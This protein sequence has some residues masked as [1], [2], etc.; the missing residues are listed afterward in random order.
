M[1]MRRT[2]PLLCLLLVCDV[3][4]AET[5]KLKSGRII[6][7]K[8]VEHTADA[9]KV[10][11]GIGVVTTYYLDEIESIDGESNADRTDLGKAT[12]SSSILGAGKELHLR[13]VPTKEGPEEQVEFH[14]DG[15][16]SMPVGKKPFLVLNRT[17]FSKIELKENLWGTVLLVISLKDESKE[18]MLRI[19]NENIGR[20]FVITD[21]DDQAYYNVSIA[22]TID[23]RTSGGS[24]FK[25]KEEIKDGFLV[26]SHF[27][28]AASQAQAKFLIDELMPEGV[29]RRMKAV[30]KYDLSS[31]K[32][33]TIYKIH[34][35][36]GGSAEGVIVDKTD[37]YFILK[38][39]GDMLI[40]FPLEDI[41]TQEA[42]DSGIKQVSGQMRMEKKPRL[43]GAPPF[44]PTNLY[45]KAVKELD[46]HNTPGIGFVSQYSKGEKQ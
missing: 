22:Q 36:G 31:L 46:Y 4:F 35:G 25:I 30:D 15:H 1:G 38:T 37:E 13:W 45:A 20:S 23:H 10:D 16:I 2:L 6:D 14:G 34:V 33:T 40:S 27:L 8:V 9:I 3:A 26:I 43:E 42:I 17:D 19:L 41:I 32:D 12:E 24:D 44:E 28:K 21:G 11:M 5:I 39:D 7:G 18:R 29:D